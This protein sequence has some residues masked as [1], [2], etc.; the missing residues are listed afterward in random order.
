MRARICC[1]RRSLYRGTVYDGT[2]QACQLLGTGNTENTEVIP[3]TETEDEV[4]RVDLFVVRVVHEPFRAKHCR[5]RVDV[6]VLG[7]APEGSTSILAAQK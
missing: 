2:G 1:C 4:L 5:I 6:C 7:H 3:A